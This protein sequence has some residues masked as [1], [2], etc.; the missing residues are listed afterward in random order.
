M[1]EN[2]LIITKVKK[3]IEYLDKIIENFPN[4]ETVLRNELNIKCYK[5]LETSYYAKHSIDE[6]KY[7]YQLDMI[8]CIKMIDYYLKRSMDKKII[9]YQKYTKIGNH[10]LEL[11]KMIQMW[12]KNEKNRQ[13]IS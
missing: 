8:V 9:S 6:N 12:I 13:Y 5:L 4:K 1:K 7:Q 3:T 2:M 10:L 11:I